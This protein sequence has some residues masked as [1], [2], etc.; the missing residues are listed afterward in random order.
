LLI[1]KAVVAR[2]RRERERERERREK[3]RRE[4]CTFSHDSNPLFLQIIAGIT[5]YVVILRSASM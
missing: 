5:T 2:R 3:E 4:K 1:Q